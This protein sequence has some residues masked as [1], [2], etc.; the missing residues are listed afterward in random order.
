MEENKR[1]ELVALLVELDLHEVHHE[2][3]RFMDKKDKEKA[4]ELLNVKEAITTILNYL[5]K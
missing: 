1:N 3:N 5:E 4:L 2:L